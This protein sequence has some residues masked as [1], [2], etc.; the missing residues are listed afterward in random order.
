[1]G[2]SAVRTVR[3]S[4][5]REVAYP[6][7]HVWQAMATLLPYCSVCDVSAVVDT[8]GEVGVGTAFRAFRGPIAAPTDGDVVEGG[9]PGEIVIVEGGMPGEIVDWSPQRSV[10]TRLEAGG[11]TVRVGVDMAAASPDTT[12]VTISVEV[13]PVLRSRVAAVM[14]R[15][16]YLRMAKRTVE[17]EIEKLPAHLALL[18]END[19]H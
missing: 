1:M 15:T 19:V 5:A 18:E 6:V 2:R 9:M 14:T 17:G 13:T 7:E 16:S 11:E 8:P 10:A 4:A 12:L 3:A